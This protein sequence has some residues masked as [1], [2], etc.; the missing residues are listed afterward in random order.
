MKQ[1]KYYAT[2]ESDGSVLV[3]DSLREAVEYVERDNV[4][5]FSFTLTPLGSYEVKT[6]V[7]K[8]KPKKREKKK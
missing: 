1:K 8:I 4:S 7:A 5:V 3:S 2:L 6:V